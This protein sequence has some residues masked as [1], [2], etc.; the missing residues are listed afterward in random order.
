MLTLYL[1]LKTKH[2]YPDLFNEYSISLRLYT[3]THF[4]ITMFG[5]FM[6]C[7]SWFPLFGLFAFILCLSYYSL[8]S[9]VWWLMNYPVIPNNEAFRRWLKAQ[10]AVVCFIR[11]LPSGRFLLFALENPELHC[12]IVI[13]PGPINFMEGILLVFCLKKEIGLQ[14]LGEPRNMVSRNGSPACRLILT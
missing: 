7:C 2:F 3:H 14:G 4:L 13:S 12:L 1:S 6:L 11:D 9:E 8:S 5:F 10:V